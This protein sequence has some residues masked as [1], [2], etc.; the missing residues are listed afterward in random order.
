[1][2]Y[3]LIN[4]EPEPRIVTKDGEPLIYKDKHTAIREA[5]KFKKGLVYPI[6]D[7]MKIFEAIS[8]MCR[9]YTGDKRKQDLLE[10][11]RII[12]DDVV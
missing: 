9:E 1:M 3:L 4:L 5:N 2:D 11:L 10:R 8:V 6:A 12:I 7:V